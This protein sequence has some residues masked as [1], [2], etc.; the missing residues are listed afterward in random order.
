MLYP[1]VSATICCDVHPMPVDS[2][3]DRSEEVYRSPEITVRAVTLRPPN[4]IPRRI[5]VRTRPNNPE[6]EPGDLS[7]DQLHR[8]HE[9]IIAAMFK[10]AR[11]LERL[12]GDAPDFIKITRPVDRY[13]LPLASPDENET[14]LVYICQAAPIPGKFDNSKAKALNV[15]NGPIR[16]E[17]VLGKTVEFDDKSVRGGRRIVRPEDVIGG[18]GPGAVSELAVFNSS[19]R[20]A[21][22]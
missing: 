3:S 17:L 19:A 22:F 8:W 2:S 14:D 20:W 13:P 1:N 4:S 12:H 11:K 9:N 10:P 6:L 21:D 7:P 15:P 5:S 18:G 16:S